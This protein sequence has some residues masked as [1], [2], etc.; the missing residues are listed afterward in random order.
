MKTEE[1]MVKNNW[2][3]N[4]VLMMK[5]YNVISHF[6]RAKRMHPCLIPFYLRDERGDTFEKNCTSGV[7]G[8]TSDI[9]KLNQ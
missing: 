1:K 7:D 5:M 4:V 6:Y 8:S 3:M 2:N 9:D